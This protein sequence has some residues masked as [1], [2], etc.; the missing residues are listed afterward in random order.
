MVDLEDVTCPE[1]TFAIRRHYVNGTDVTDSIIDGGITTLTGGKGGL[2]GSQHWFR[3][4]GWSDYLI[5]AVDNDY[6]TV[7]SYAGSLRVHVTYYA[8]IDYDADANSVNA[9]VVRVGQIV[10]KVAAGDDLPMVKDPETEGPTNET[11]T[12]PEV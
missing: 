5:P 11:I 2:I 8:Y 7:W 3:W 6:E 4:N 12:V 9:V 10:G 1:G